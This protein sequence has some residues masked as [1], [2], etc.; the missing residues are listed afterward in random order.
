MTQRVL[1]DTFACLERMVDRA[2]RREDVDDGERPPLQASLRRMLA[3]GSG[4]SPLADADPGGNA[5]ATTP[6]P[7]ERPRASSAFVNIAVIVRRDRSFPAIRAAVVLGQLAKHGRIVRT[8]PPMAALRTGRFDGRLLV[9]L[10]SVLPSRTLAGKIAA[11]DEIETFTLAPAEEPEPTTLPEAPALSLRVR[12]DRL[13][14]VIEDVL[15]L[16]S[17]LGR[18]DARLGSTPGSPAARDGE[19][20]RRLARRTYDALVELRLVPFETASQRLVHA[21]EELSRRLGKEAS[22]QVEGQD[23]RIDRSLLEHLMD[24]L[25]HMVRNAIDHGIETPSARRAAHKPD[26]GRVAVGLVRQ[27]SGLTLVVEDD[28]RGL[29]P[30]RLKQVGIERGLLT[31]SQAVRMDD[32][33]A[34]HLITLAGF[35]TVEE[36]TEVSGRGVGMDV[37]RG[38]VETL[39]GRLE[40]A[41]QVG[42]GTRFAVT[43]PS[44]VALVQAY[45]V[46]ASGVVFA[47]PLAAIT[48]MAA[49]D[50][51]ST[52]WRDGRR[53]WSIGADDVPVTALRDLLR[54]EGPVPARGG[55]AL[56]A[57]RPGSGTA[58]IEVDEVLG[59]CEVVVRPLPPPLAGVSG[60]SGATVLDDGSIVLV[61]D[62]ARLPRV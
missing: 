23:V 11:I 20:A 16:M 54:L 47:V 35:S 1:C 34:L 40:I 46:R 6:S 41:S 31:P 42:R 56:L 9:T 50:D 51:H 48:R 58:G 3:D 61:L 55:M 12:A 38:T 17:S 62:P 8:D 22:L 32:A 27:A 10:G 21:A 43:I 60:Y 45:L 33:E 24:P 19:M 15:E 49:M 59:R 57:D 53:F 30:R 52:T 7:V 4:A 14:G 37:V 39:G 26:A 44:S 36:T 28:G 18:I 25:L 2:G 29:D 13:D 5:G